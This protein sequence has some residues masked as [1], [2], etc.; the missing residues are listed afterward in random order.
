M[1]KAAGFGLKNKSSHLPYHLTQTDGGDYGIVLRAESLTSLS[2]NPL[3]SE[4]EALCFDGR[5]YTIVVE[6][7]DVAGRTASQTCTVNV[8]LPAPF[9]PEDC[10]AKFPQSG[11]TPRVFTLANSAAPN[12]EASC[13]PNEYF[14]LLALGQAS[15]LEPPK[16]LGCDGFDSNCGR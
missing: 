4:C 3:E 12:L 7:T 8:D 1:H 9:Q 15:G 14:R 6:A 13:R 10:A 5:S 2:C 11:A 16:G